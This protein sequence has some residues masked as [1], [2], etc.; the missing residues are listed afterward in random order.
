MR[1]GVL[2]NTWLVNNDLCISAEPASYDYSLQTGE[3]SRCLNS[4]VNPLSAV[5]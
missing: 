4:Y 2:L 3:P 5:G 1:L